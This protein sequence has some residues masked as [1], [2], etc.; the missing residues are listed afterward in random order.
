MAGGKDYRETIDHVTSSAAV[1]VR[2]QLVDTQAKHDS[3]AGLLW[4]QQDEDAV[5]LAVVV[6]RG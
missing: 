3:E 2:E 5:R 4:L 6:E 1:K